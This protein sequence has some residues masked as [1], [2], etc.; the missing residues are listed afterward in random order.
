MRLLRVVFFFLHLSPPPPHLC[1]CAHSLSIFLPTC[2]SCLPT[3]FLCVTPSI[4]M[5]DAMKQSVSVNFFL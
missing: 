2:H 1:V 3:P 5:Y 4:L